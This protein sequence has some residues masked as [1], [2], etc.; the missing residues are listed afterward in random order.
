MARGVICLVVSFVS[1]RSA[2]IGS[3]SPVSRSSS[4]GNYILFPPPVF[5]T[6]ALF[7]LFLLGTTSDHSTHTPTTIP[8]QYRESNSLFVSFKCRDSNFQL[9]NS[10][11][12]AALQILYLHWRG[13][14]HS[15]DHFHIG[16]RQQEISLENRTFLVV[17]KA[18]NLLQPSFV[19]RAGSSTDLHTMS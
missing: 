13:E 15:K 6:F 19:T 10:S 7:F 2:L 9:C 17:L 3:H 12:Q 14:K 1:S 11:K 4:S 5:S 18:R 16:V 8:F